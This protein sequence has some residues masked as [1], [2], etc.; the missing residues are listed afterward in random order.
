[1]TE[2]L[3]IGIISQNEKLWSLYA[4]NK[5]LNKLCSNSRYNVKGFW[6]CE[7]KF[8]NLKHKKVSKWYFETFGMW[9]FIKLGIFYILFRI[10]KMFSSF[11]GKYSN[12]FSNL[13]KVNK[14]KYYSTSS[15]NSKEFIKWVKEEQIDILV[16]MV[17]HI[18]KKE[19]IATVKIGIINKHA[20][21]LPSNKGVFP[22][23]WAKLKDETQG[24]SFHIVDEKIDNGKLLYQ[25]KVTKS[26]II[27][28]MISFYLYNYRTYNNA[29]QIALNNLIENTTEKIDP[30][31]KESYCGLPEISDLKKFNKKKGKI[32]TFSDIIS[33]AK[34]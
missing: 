32:I 4:W 7:E 29:L 20:G 23:I 6:T 2:K 19:I 16:I 10:K 33:I 5:T 14:V 15:P 8:A 1:M 9:N 28:S 17:G 22:Y 24:I 26:T 34:I 12:S 11:I 27:N 21:L 31:I 3:N 13:C 18:L 30:S 25:E